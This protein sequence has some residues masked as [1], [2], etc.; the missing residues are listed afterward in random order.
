M[1][2]L[3]DQHSV[4][5]HFLSELRDVKIQ[6]D[7]LKFRTNLK[8][9]G[10][11][12]AYEISKSLTYR[13]KTIETPLAKTN[14]SV[15]KDEIVLI[16]I[17]RAA[18][19][20]YEGFRDVFDTADSGFIGAWRKEETG[21]K[22]DVNLDYMAAPDLNGKTVMVIDPMLATGKSAVKCIHQ[23][24]ENGQPDQLHMASVIA[25]PEGVDYI[26]QNIGFPFQLWTCALDERLNDQSYIVPG[27][28]DAGDL[29][30]GAK[31]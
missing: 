23:L 30:F 7:R 10:M 14:T 2:I 4:A 12:L 26:N 16:T 20:F 27:L 29:S 21:N 5:N 17:M 9:L 18:L 24:L 25:A 6:G 8:R 15:I 13:Q 28:G 31:L 1:F 3:A 22:I 11:L 19:P